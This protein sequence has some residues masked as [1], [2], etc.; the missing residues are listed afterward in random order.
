MKRT[1]ISVAACLLVWLCGGVDGR[2]QRHGVMYHYPQWSPDGRSI[3]VS[4]IL[5]DDSDSELYLISLRDGKQTKLT[6]NSAAD[7]TGRWLP[8]GRILFLSDRRGQLETFVMNA[9][10]TNQQPTPYDDDVT[11]TSPDGLTQLRE[12]N[13]VIYSVDVATR[14]R[15]AVSSGARAEQGTFSPDGAWI[16]FEQRS[17]K[18]PDQIRLSNIVVARVDGSDAKAVS[19]GTD[20]SWSPDGSHLVFKVWDEKAQQLFITTV[21]RDGTDARRLGPGVHP[22]WSPDGKRIAFMR[23]TGDRM[24]VWVM[25]HDGTDQRCVTCQVQ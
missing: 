21:R 2:T 15:R 19:R 4:A 6:D 17:A 1:I 18:A 20:P 24:D 10:G 8:D 13:G 5:T 23:E 9:D 7:D 16:V 22:H 3:L 11:S 12:E 14:A 25:A